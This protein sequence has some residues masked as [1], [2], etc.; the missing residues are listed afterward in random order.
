MFTPGQVAHYA[1]P[2]TQTQAQAQVASARGSV[3][4]ARAVVNGENVVTYAAL[5]TAASGG[6]SVAPTYPSGIVAGHYLTLHV[7][8]GATND[9]T[10]TTPSG[11]T[12][13]A[14]GTGTD[15][16]AFGVDNGP[17]RATVFGKIADGTES[18]TLTVNITN[19]NTCRGNFIRWTKTEGSGS[20][21]V[22]GQGGGDS[23]DGTGFSVT[24]GSINWLDGDAGVVT[25]GQNPDSVT[26][27][28][29]SLTATGIT[30]GT[31]TN[32]ATDNVITGNDHRHVIDTFAAVSNAATPEDAAPTWA[33]TG[34]AACV[35]GAVI[36]RLRAASNI[37]YVA[38]GEGFAHDAQVGLSYGTTTNA[39]ATVA[40]GTGTAHQA[41]VTITPAAGV[42][43]ATGTSQTP[44][45]KV[46]PPATVATATGTGSD[47]TT[48]VSPT[49]A[50]ASGTGTAQTPQVTIAVPAG[51][52]S[53][54]G[55]GHD[56]TVS[57]GTFTNAPAEVASGTGVGHDATVKISPTAGAA[58]ATGT[59]Q[60]ATAAVAPNGGAASGT[61]TATGA[62]GTVAPV[63]G[64][65]TGTATANA[66]NPAVAP[67]AGAATGT[68]TGHDATVSTAG[69]NTNA[70]ATVAS[71][72]GTASDAAVK[73]S[74]NATVASGT[75]TATTAQASVAPNAGSGS[76]TGTGQTANT[77]VAST[78]AVASGTGAAQTAVADTGVAITRQVYG[79]LTGPVHTGGGLTG[80][81]HTGGSL[82]DA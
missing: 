81:T 28:A 1:Q 31:V 13:L 66:P 40:S 38:Y 80:P 39:P 74:P 5:G 42:A 43:S 79:A 75:G 24:F 67:N 15:G 2:G 76:S 51:V 72:T 68:G 32:R 48:K 9:E 61:G 7:T 64:T 17:R 22:V 23:T 35:G 18:G 41:T 82:V 44:N 71:G 36:V 45:A 53:A 56:A 63:L 57:V 20:W 33:Y 73:I 27:S 8:S 11:W 6:A 12:L 10:P 29:Q 70:P 26:Q 59:A 21:D 65:A 77:A 54:T 60:T 49:A 19:G 62:T 25:V 78:A 34:S 55:V 50:V 58:S 14:T 16:S 4:D 52:A 30:F 37:A 47:G 46:E 3:R 69:S